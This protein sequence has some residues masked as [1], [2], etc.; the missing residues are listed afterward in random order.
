MSVYMFFITLATSGINIAVT[1]IIVEKTAFGEHT[2]TRFAMRKCFIYSLVFG[3][4]ACLLLCAF[5]KPIT[6]F[7]VK[8]QVSYYVFYFIGISLP[9]ISMSSCLNGYFSAL[10]KNGKNAISRVF[11]QT[12]K[13]IATSL[14]FLLFMPSGV[15]YACLCLVLGEMVSEIGSFLFTFILY[16]L[17][18]KR[19]TIKQSETGNYFKIITSISLPIAITSY[20]R[21]GL[22]SL[23]QLLIPISLEK[24]GL[25]HTDAISKYGLISGMVMPILLFPEVIINSFS[26]LV[27]PEY[28]YFDTKRAKKKISYATSRIFRIT[29]LF[30]IGI[31]GVFFFYNKELSFAIYQNFEIAIY[32]KV[33]SPLIFFMYL[34]SIV[35]NILKGLNQQLGVMKCN[36]L[37]LFTSIFFIYC[38]LPI[39]GLSG[40]IIV[41]YFSELL[42]SF[43]SLYQLNK[44]THLKIDFINWI[45]K[46]ILGIT[47][48]F[49]VCKLLIPISILTTFSII[50][51]ITIFLLGYFVFLLLSHAF[52]S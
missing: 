21:S 16:K 8:N 36:I 6:N 5:S 20:I 48:S 7:F 50:L 14:F 33:L 15:Y 10:R 52:D 34:D 37:D 47:I 26:G 11:E 1:R 3:I 23:K 45:I 12:L 25:S 46:P 18:T 39:F 28:A 4:F 32:L 22:S 2:D 17:E 13:M 49:L 27:V 42:N 19:H 40:Y 51:H 29:F 38:L 9:F 31:F 24:H 44:L 35:D 41:I 43:V 30:S